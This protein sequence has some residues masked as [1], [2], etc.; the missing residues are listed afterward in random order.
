M[1]CLHLGAA[2]LFVG[3]LDYGV[4]YVGFWLVRTLFVV[5]VVYI[6]S[7]FMVGMLLEWTIR[8]RK[9]D[10]S[11]ITPADLLPIFPMM[12]AGTLGSGLAS[13]LPPT[14]AGYVIVV[15]YMLQSMGFFIGLLKCVLGPL[16]VPSRVGRIVQ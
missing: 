15:S 11:T 14:Q 9:R 7:A 2:T 3:I 8:G 6:A 5:W 1:P 10:L 4:P 12:L 16:I 13:Q